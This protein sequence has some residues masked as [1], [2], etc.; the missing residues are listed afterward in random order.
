[1]KGLLVIYVR[2]IPFGDSYAFSVPRLEKQS[3]SGRGS[4]ESEIDFPEWVMGLRLW[5]VVERDI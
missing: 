3:G 5:S 1:M 2:Q 4:Q